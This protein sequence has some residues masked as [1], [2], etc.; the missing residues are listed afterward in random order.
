MGIL[1]AAAFLGA[2]S[3][4]PEDNTIPVDATAILFALVLGGALLFR[5]RWPLGVFVAS[6]L[7]TTPAPSTAT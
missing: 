6:L 7:V 4:S 3:I 1:T 2:A 5:R